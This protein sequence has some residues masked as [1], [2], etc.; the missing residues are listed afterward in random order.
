MKESKA[1][2]RACNHDDR[3]IC[4]TLDRTGEIISRDFKLS[5][6]QAMAYL[7]TIWEILIFYFL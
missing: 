5:L 6:D 3:S 2:G 4:N 1:L 7:G